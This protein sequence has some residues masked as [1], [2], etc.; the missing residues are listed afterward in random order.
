VSREPLSLPELVASDVLEPPPWAYEDLPPL[1]SM[2]RTTAT[3]DLGSA[4]PYYGP[5]RYDGNLSH[6]PPPPCPMHIPA[7][8]R[9][10][11]AWIAG[12]EDPCAYIFPA[13]LLFEITDGPDRGGTIVV[14][15][16]A[17]D[18]PEMALV[19]AIVPETD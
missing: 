13:G 8:T 16:A 17:R 11:F 3:L 9:L 19:R 1:G 6:Y 4:R 7:G 10:R 14:Y 2:W 18:D 12:C 15:P 5:N